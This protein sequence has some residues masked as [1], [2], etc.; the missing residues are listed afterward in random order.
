MKR[1]EPISL[2]EMVG[3]A[4]FVVFFLV[5]FI[6]FFTPQPQ[7]EKCKTIIKD[8]QYYC[9]NNNTI[10]LLNETQVL[11]ESFITNVC[12]SYDNVF[13]YFL[14]EARPCIYDVGV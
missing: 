6:V 13:I 12:G 9:K 4:L 7:A 11:N 14:Q 3:I 8:V 5:L 2:D 10:I 1:I